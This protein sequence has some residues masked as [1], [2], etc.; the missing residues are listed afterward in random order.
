MTPEQQKRLPPTASTLL[1]LGG[2]LVGGAAANQDN[3]RDYDFLFEPTEWS[4]G[5]CCLIPALLQGDAPRLTR[6]GGIRVEIDRITYDVWT[7]TLGNFIARA[8]GSGTA[9]NGKFNKT[10]RW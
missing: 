10:I 5:A 9:F 1:R 2:W 3:P 8:P 6:F 7:D 4:G